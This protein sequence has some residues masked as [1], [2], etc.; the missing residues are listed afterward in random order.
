MGSVKKYNRKAT[1]AVS[2]TKKGRIFT[3][4]NKRAKVVAKK[5]GKRTRLT[6]AD[7]KAL[8]NTGTY[9]YYQYTETGSLRP[10]RL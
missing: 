4:V 1:F 5:A 9:K 2:T 6:V 3:P 7:L 8:K 10:V